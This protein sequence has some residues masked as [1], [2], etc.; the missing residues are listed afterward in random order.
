MPDSRTIPAPNSNDRRAPNNSRLSGSRPSASVPSRWRAF[1]PTNRSES[2]EAY[3]SY[4]AASGPSN[5]ARARIKSRTMPVMGMPDPQM[6]AVLDQLMML[7]A[8]PIET[9]A[10]RQ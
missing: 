10:P 4:G 7:G 1:G 5:A 6:Q 2:A 3:G 8:S 9:L